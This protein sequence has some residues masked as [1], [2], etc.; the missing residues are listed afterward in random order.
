[1]GPTRVAVPK[2][3][4]KERTETER[5]S[6]KKR[7]TCLVQN[8]FN[9]FPWKLKEEIVLGRIAVGGGVKPI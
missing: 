5:G 3:A 8:P 7:E 6:M 4:E 1:M 9:N 2:V